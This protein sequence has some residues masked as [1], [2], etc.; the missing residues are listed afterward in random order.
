MRSPAR[1][2]VRLTFLTAVALIGPGCKKDRPH[3][4]PGVAV[5][6]PT[7]SATWIRNFN[8]FFGSQARWPTTAGIYEPLLIYN[9]VQQRYVPWLA[10]SYRWEQDGRALVMKLRDGVEW[11]DGAPFTPRDVVFTWQLIRK[12]KALDQAGMWKKL[13]SVTASE[14]EAT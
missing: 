5:V 12:H 2:L 7:Q 14:E 4:E 11:S 3:H 1:W 6:V 10:E 9:T 8:P 13:E